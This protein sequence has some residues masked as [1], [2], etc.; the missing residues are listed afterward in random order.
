MKKTLAR[1][2]LIVAVVIVLLTVA[3]AWLWVSSYKT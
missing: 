2:I 1:F 3:A